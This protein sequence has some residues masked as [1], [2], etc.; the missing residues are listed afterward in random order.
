MTQSFSL[1][2]N[3]LINNNKKISF[4]FNGP[5]YFG[6]AGATCAS[7]LL[8]NGVNVIGQNC[9]YRRPSGVFIAGM[10]GP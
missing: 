9:T 3:G 2:N 4:N 8:A 6:Y 1:D 7:A 10:D 5:N